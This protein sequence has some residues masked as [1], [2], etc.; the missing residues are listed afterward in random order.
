MHKKHAK[1]G[2]VV[3]SVSLDTIDDDDPK[4]N[5]KTKAGV[6]RFLKEKGAT[7]TNLLLDEPS[8]VYQERLRF[9]A[10]PCLDVFSRQGKWTQFDSDKVKIRH[11]DVDRLV[12]ELLKE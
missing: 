5:D 4:E 10:P 11:E 9:V 3:I 6:L 2:L 12:L 1:D 7:C 8:K